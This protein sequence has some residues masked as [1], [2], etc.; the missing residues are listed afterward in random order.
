MVY[1]FKPKAFRGLHSLALTGALALIGAGTAA[2]NSITFAQFVESNGAQDWSVSE[3]T[4]GG[5]TTTTVT[6]TG[7]VYFSFEGA[8]SPF[9]GAPQLANF[10][11]SATSTSVGNCSINC[12]NGDGY[13][14]AGYTGSFSITD[15]VT[16]SGYGSDFLSGS[17]AITSGSAGTTGAQLTGNINSNNASFTASQTTGNENQLYLASSYLTFPAGSTQEV[18]SF[19]LSSFDLVPSGNGLAVTTPVSTQAYP[20]G[21]YTAAG[22]GTFSTNTPVSVS[23]EPTTTALIGSGLLVFGLLRRRKLVARKSL[24]A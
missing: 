5:I 20:S 13:Q 12:G 7:Q 2:A 16:G 21:S 9:G 6:E 3:S 23:P 4:S 19:S 8:G 24:T 14:Q 22:S 11:L 1:A 15:A 18:A 10:T 17:F